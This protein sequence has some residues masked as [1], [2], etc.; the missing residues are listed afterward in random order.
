M[1]WHWHNVSDWPIG[2]TIATWVAPAVCVAIV[3]C[4]VF[5]W[6]QW[7]ALQRFDQAKQQAYQAGKQQQHL[8]HKLHI[9]KQQLAKIPMLPQ[10]QSQ[11]LR[12]YLQRFAQFYQ[13][14]WQRLE[15]HEGTW[16]IVGV[17][18]YGVIPAFQQALMHLPLAWQWRT[19]TLRPQANSQQVRFE[20]ALILKKGMGQTS[21][22][23]PTHFMPLTQTMS[24]F[25]QYGTLAKKSVGYIQ[26]GQQRY[27]ASTEHGKWQLSTQRGQG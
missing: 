17:V 7:Q 23:W 26:M 20:A 19:I 16:H 1:R 11:A 21:L 15:Q 14:K 24:P 13:I 12:H 25:R 3:W 9:K 5:S 22:K 10:W 27:L 8:A 2:L 18:P 6:P 4:A